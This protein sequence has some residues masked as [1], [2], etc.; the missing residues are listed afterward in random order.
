M[1]NSLGKWTKIIFV[2]ALFVLSLISGCGDGNSEQNAAPTPVPNVDAGGQ[3][4]SCDQLEDRL[5]SEYRRLRQCSTDDEC[6]YIERFYEVIPRSVTDRQVTQFDCASDSPFLIVANGNFVEN[7][8]G[9]LTSL[10]QA[11]ARACAPAP[12]TIR[13]QAFSEFPS[14]P[15]PR[16]VSGVCM[17]SDVE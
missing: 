16:C 3:D 1:K 11:Q 5:L 15:P 13:C 4:L 9:A 14:S 10:Q 6:N 12:G 2:F 17:Q 8:R 7:N